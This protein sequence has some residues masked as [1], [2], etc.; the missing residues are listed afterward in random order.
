MGK[1]PLSF[2]VVVVTKTFVV[3][4]PSERAA[5][6]EV[7]SSLPLDFDSRM[8]KQS[9]V[10]VQAKTDEEMK[11]YPAAIKGS[12]V[13]LYYDQSDDEYRTFDGTTLYEA[14]KIRKAAKAGKE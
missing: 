2:Y 13:I 3:L 8:N 4:A 7:I 11:K 10:V 12:K 1:K 9:T 5:K 6:A 14:L